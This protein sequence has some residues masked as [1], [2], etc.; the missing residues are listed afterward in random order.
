MGLYL[1]AEEAYLWSISGFRL[2]TKPRG[3]SEIMEGP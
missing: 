2:F 3:M 1:G